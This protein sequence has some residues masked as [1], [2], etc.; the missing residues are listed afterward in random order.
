MTTYSDLLKLKIQ[1]IKMMASSGYDVSDDLPVLSYKP[2]NMK[3]YFEYAKDDTE[4][5]AIRRCLHDN[6]IMTDRTCLSTIYESKIRPNH[7]S[8]VFFAPLPPSKKNSLSKSLI[9]GPVSLCALFPFAKRAYC[10]PCTESLTGIKKCPRCPIKQFCEDCEGDLKCEDCTKDKWCSSCSSRQK[11]WFNYRSSLQHCSKCPQEGGFCEPCS[12]DKSARSCEECK[13]ETNSSDK[14]CK[15]CMEKLK[16]DKCTNKNFCTDCTKMKDVRGCEK[17]PNPQFCRECFTRSGFKACKKCPPPPQVIERFVI[18]SHVPLSVDAKA[19]ASANVPRIK[20]STG[21]WVETGCLIQVFL[22]REMSY[23]PLIHTYKSTY[24][25]LSIEEGVELFRSKD[26]NV[27]ENQIYQF[28]SNEQISK[29]LG[30][31]PGNV[32]RVQRKQVVPGCMA[33]WEVI[34]RV[35]RPIPISRKNRKRALKP[36]AEVVTSSAADNDQWS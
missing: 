4:K 34:Y 5:N 35:V 32:I 29:Y 26:N 6:G 10:G 24:Y 21:D 27:T 14:D 22:D 7:H 13:K 33:K 19:T 23:N 28:D 3:D 20:P 16:C 2:E 18:I 9:E 15:G 17:C 30:L 31:F 11:K 25:I 8:V 36:T 1:S 12:H